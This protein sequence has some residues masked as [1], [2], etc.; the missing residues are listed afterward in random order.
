MVA[1]ATVLVPSSGAGA[2][3]NAWPSTATP[4]AN[5]LGEND[6]IESFGDALRIEGR[7]T[8]N[9]PVVG[10]ASS[11]T[12]G[13]LGV[14]ADGGVFALGGAAFH[15]SAAGLPHAPMTAIATTPT[16]SGYWLA[17]ATGEVFAFGDAGRF[18]DLSTLRL[19]AP[20]VSMARTASGN[21]Y[22][23]AASDGGVFAFGD[24]V[25]AGS[26]ASLP[27]RQPIVTMTVP[28]SGLGYWL[29]AADGG[30]FSYG[31]A[32]FYGSL[33]GI[34]LNASVASGAATPTGAG[35]WL[36]GADGGVFAFGD[37]PFLGSGS[38]SSLGRA[39]SILPTPS[40]RG[41]R[42]GTDQ[43]CAP[44]GMTTATTTMQGGSQ[45]FLADVSVSASSCV[46]RTVFTFAQGASKEFVGTVITEVGY[47]SEP[48][49][50]IAGFPLWVNGG[51]ALQVRMDGASFYDINTGT[52]TYDGATAFVGPPGGPVKEVRLIDAFEG[53][54]TWAIG[55]DGPR[56]FRVT[57][58]LNPTRVIVDVWADVAHSVTTPTTSLSLY[59]IENGVLVPRSVVVPA[60][61]ATLRTSLEMLVGPIAIDPARPDLTSELPRALEVASAR[62]LRI[63]GTTA[64]IDLSQQ[65]T[66]ATPESL[67]ARLAQVVY[68]A[69]Q[70]PTVR[71]VQFYVN[72]V[73]FLG[74]LTRADVTL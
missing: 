38:S 19:N 72:G 68:T 69:T 34:P 42:I 52:P 22:W 35:Y 63:V 3:P 13:V 46:E 56:P 70:F 33:G 1:A 29:I 28:P 36:V 57:Q 64:E 39:V 59:Y 11:P 2:A 21:G 25:F 20:I 54:M 7:L 65:F 48:F 16:G 32:R 5:A 41:Y 4:T 53:I 31:D 44:A 49:S 66:E 12:G 62:P 9:A 30:V 73:A 58:R 67:K 74:P 37:A 43:S 71:S 24:A 17:S 27:L 60:T 61:T 14:G 23:L 51:A 40:G 6:A 8:L 18:G 26:A 47:A 45:H 15:G 50:N 10:Y 55:V